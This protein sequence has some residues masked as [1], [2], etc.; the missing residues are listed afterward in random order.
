MYFAYLS[1]FQVFQDQQFPKA[2]AHIWTLAVEE[3]FYLVWPLVILFVPQRHFLKTFVSVIIACVILRL[4]TYAPQPVIPQVI[5]TQYCVDA[6]AIG[7]LLAYK[8]TMASD[9]EI[10][11]INRWFNIILYAGIPVSIY[12]IF[13]HADYLSYGINRLVF[14]MISLKVIEGAVN[15][16]KNFFGKFLENKTVVSIGRISYGIYLYHLLVPVVF[17]KIYSF[18]YH[19]EKTAHPGFFA[20]HKAFISGFQHVIVTEA[21]G[22]VIYSVLVIIVARLSW[23]FIEMPFFKFKISYDQGI[24]KTALKFFNKSAV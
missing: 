4:V 13:T 17:W 5:L 22:F 21:A 18:C 11:I 24:R 23:K 7:S 1:N 2:G 20:K 12:I 15:G 14:S 9:K 8:T 19:Y 10:R 16:Y 6:F 3:Q